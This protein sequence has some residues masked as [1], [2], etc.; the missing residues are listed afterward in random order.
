[1][2]NVWIILSS[3]IVI[4]NS[5]LQSKSFIIN[6]SL[7]I[8]HWFPSHL[9]LITRVHDLYQRSHPW[10]SYQNK[11]CIY[12]K[13]DFCGIHTFFKFQDQYLGSSQTIRIHPEFRREGRREK[14]IHQYK[15]QESDR[16]GEWCSEYKI[17]FQAFKAMVCK[18]QGYHLGCRREGNRHHLHQS[19]TH[20]CARCQ[21][22]ETRL[23]AYSGNILN[24][25]NN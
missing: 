12:G 15:A 1:M 14:E 3:S 17:L 20:A 21:T 25:T 2:N 18:L 8:I 23:R 16:S 19:M 4:Y 10:S 7:F 13:K 6:Y 5:P 24:P 11:E 9:S 22:E